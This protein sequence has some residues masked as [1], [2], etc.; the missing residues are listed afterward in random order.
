MLDFNFSKI[1]EAD[2][3]HE[4][5]FE[6]G[7][8]IITVLEAGNIRHKTFCREPDP[9]VQITVGKQKATSKT[10]RGNPNPE[11]TFKQLFKLS[12]YT[13]NNKS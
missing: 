11:W 7:Q 4:K 13:K 5:S 9:Y 3:K 1:E 6:A 12:K 2:A 10:V 8:L